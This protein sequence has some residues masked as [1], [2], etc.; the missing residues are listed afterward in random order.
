MIEYYDDSKQFSS[1]IAEKYLNILESKGSKQEKATFISRIGVSEDYIT[2]ENSEQKIIKKI[3][4]TEVPTLSFFSEFEFGT[5][6]RFVQESSSTCY[7]CLK[8][9]IL[10]LTKIGYII[11]VTDGIES[12]LIM[13]L[14]N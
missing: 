12:S 10:Y 11:D 5:S 3:H 6:V 7:R 14:K 9:I 8:R 1:I 4:K 2:M 13:V